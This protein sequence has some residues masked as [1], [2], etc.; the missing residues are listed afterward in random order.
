MRLDINVPDIDFQTEE[1]RRRLAAMLLKLFQHWRLTA[2]DQT[3]L[4]GLSHDHGR[5][6]LEECRAGGALPD[7]NLVVLRACHLLSIHTS[8]Q[9]LL[10]DNSGLVVAWLTS[11]NQQF[12]AQP[13]DVMRLRG[14]DGL[15]DVR[16]YLASV[17]HC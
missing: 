15:I 6:A 14:I 3:A 10:S 11:H 13:L 8:L 2:A 12:N 9:Q 5:A 17:T 16:N 1:S 7:D 4:L